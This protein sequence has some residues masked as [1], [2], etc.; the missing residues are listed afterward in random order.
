[1]H[2]STC[3]F[4]QIEGENLVDDI[5]K[6]LKETKINISIMYLHK[7]RYKKWNINEILRLHREYELL[8][9][10]I[11]EIAKNHSRSERAILCRLE[12]EGFIENWNEARGFY[13]YGITQPELY[14]YVMHLQTY[15]KNNADIFSKSES[16]NKTQYNNSL[17][18]YYESDNFWILKSA[19]IIVENCINYIKYAKKWVNQ[20]F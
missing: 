7:R 17:V 16:H 3:Y 15:E 19:F 6:K 12:K 5:E 10:N 20:F 18:K 11:Q 8:E 2:Y 14:E 9:L 13:E 4:H 1:V